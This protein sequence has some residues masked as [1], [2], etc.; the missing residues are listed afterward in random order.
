MPAGRPLTEIDKKTFENLCGIQCTLTE[1]AAAF[2][3]SEDT[4]ERWCEREYGSK[5]AEV[6]AIYRGRGK[7]SLR[8]A[9]FDLSKKD[10]KMAIWLGKQYL[11]QSERGVIGDGETADDGL[12][13]ALNNANEVWNDG[14]QSDVPV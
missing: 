10:A 6:F 1:F 8:R 3:C 9:Q 11:G 4:V 5:F 7:I 12:I 2:D 14:E 13:A